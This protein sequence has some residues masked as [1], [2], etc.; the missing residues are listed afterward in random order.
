MT[1]LRRALRDLDAVGPDDAVFDRAKRGPTRPDLP[2]RGASRDRIIAGVTAI[3]VFAVAG[4]FAW[5]AFDGTEDVDRDRGPAVDVVP[6]GSDGSTLWPQRTRAELEAAQTRTDAGAG[7]FRWQLD[8]DEVV[9]RFAETVLG[10]PR[11]TYRLTLDE[12]EETGGITIAHLE[13]SE[14]TCPPR[15][16]DDDDRGVGPCLPGIEDVTL[17]QPLRAGVGG[18]WTVRAVRSPAA[19]IELQPGQVVTNADSVAAD[20]RI[21]EGHS[22]AWASVIGGFDDDRD[23]FGFSGAAPPD[24]DFEIDVRIEADEIAGTDCGTRVHGYVVVAT[25]AHDLVCCGYVAD[26]LNGDSSPF[27]AVTALPMVV[28]IPENEQEPGTATYEDPMGWKIDHPSGWFVKRFS[29]APGDGLGPAVWISNVDVT[30]DS[31]PPPEAV[32]LRISPAGARPFRD[33]SSLPLSIE[34]FQIAPGVGNDSGLEF[35]GNGVP[36]AAQLVMGGGVSETDLATMA[37]VVASI[38]FP[39]L[40]DGGLQHGW[41]SLGTGDFPRG[42]GSPANPGEPLEVIYVMRAPGGGDYALDL[43]PES[44]GEGQSQ[45]WDDELLQ[46]WIRCPDGRDVRYERD[47]TPVSG[48]PPGFTQ[49][50]LAFP[51]ITAWDGSLLVSVTHPITVVEEQYWPT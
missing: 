4:T 23:C 45:T 21:A 15:T 35:R 16:P 9:G 41:L 27:V 26:P 40:R 48:N 6:L 28:T 19:A 49:P 50:L 36:Y 20:I 42:M 37:E 18:I 43:D 5:R 39:S 32:V 12:S 46:V 31:A 2:R 24:G 14:E 51:V 7:R 10:W 44:C 17:V 38:R 22:G 30:E 3:A 11:N 33:D 13:R 47:G 8:R 25:A 1:D 29:S 34:D